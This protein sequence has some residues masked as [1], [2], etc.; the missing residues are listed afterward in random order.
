MVHKLWSNIQFLPGTA[1][2]VTGPGNKAKSR[3]L[4]HVQ[5]KC[6]NYCPP[7]KSELTNFEVRSPHIKVLASVHP[8]KGGLATDRAAQVYHCGCALV[9]YMYMYIHSYECIYISSERN[10]RLTVKCA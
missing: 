6:T 2:C 8:T 9:C 1:T 5:T 4:R 10:E 3:W 7:H